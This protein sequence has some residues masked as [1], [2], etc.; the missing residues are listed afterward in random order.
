MSLPPPHPHPHPFCC[1][2]MYIK[3]TLWAHHR[4]PSFSFMQPPFDLCYVSSGFHCFSLLLTLFLIPLLVLSCF[5]FPCR[6]CPLCSWQRL[7][8]ETKW[9]CWTGWDLPCACAESRCTSGSK[10]TTPNVS[11]GFFASGKGGTGVSQPCRTRCASTHG[12]KGKAVK[13]TALLNFTAQ[14][15]RG[16]L[17]FTSRPV[18]SAS[19]SSMSRSTCPSE[20][21]CSSEQTD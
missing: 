3:F 11:D 19:L 17:M 21:W 14:L 2:E 13:L 12:R 10:R 1:A 6:K 5:L 8:W 9:V 7:W 15:R 16:P 4:C 20:S 18:R